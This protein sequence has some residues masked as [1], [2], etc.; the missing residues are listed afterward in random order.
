M[1]NHFTLSCYIAVE[2]APPNRSF[3]GGPKVHFGSD[4]EETHEDD[5]N[6][7]GQFSRHDTPHPKSHSHISKF[8]KQS[9]DGHI[10]HHDDNVS[11]TLPRL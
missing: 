7:V 6:E 1:S 2:H 3:I 11:A 5:E 8:K 4:L 9:I 10:I